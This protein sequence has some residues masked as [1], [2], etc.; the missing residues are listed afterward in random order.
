LYARVDGIETSNGFQLME[1]ELTEP[2]LFLKDYPEG[3]QN[4]LE[5]LRSG[6]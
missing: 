5:A 1:L 2:L 4:Y 3:Y 6:F